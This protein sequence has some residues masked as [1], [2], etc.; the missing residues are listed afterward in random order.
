MTTVP[1][2]TYY[3][4]AA[5]QSRRSI[6]VLAVR[7]QDTRS[8]DKCAAMATT[9]CSLLVRKL[10]TGRLMFWVQQQRYMYSVRRALGRYKLERANSWRRRCGL[11]P[12]YP[13]LYRLQRFISR[14]LCASFCACCH[15]GR[16]DRADFQGGGR[17]LK[18]LQPNTFENRVLKSFLGFCAGAL[19]TVLLNLVL[20]R[21]YQT[22][23]FVLFLVVFACGTFL[24]LGAA[25]SD[26]VRCLILLT[27]PQLF[28]RE[29][30]LALTAYIYF[31]VLT[32]PAENFAANVEVL[33]RG[34]SCGQEK[35]ANETRRMLEV[36]TSPLK[37]VYDRVK[38]VIKLL[39][40][41]GSL[42]KKAFL[43]IKNLFTEIFAAIRRAIRWLYN[44]VNVCNRRMGEPYE[45]CRKPLMDAYADCL[46]MMPDLLEWICSPVKAVEQVCYVAKVITV[47]CAI[48]AMIIDFV[49]VQVIDRIERAMRSFLERAYTA[50]YVNVTVTH[51]Y[52][53]SLEYSRTP[54]EV[55]GHVLGELHARVALF[56]A[57]FKLLSNGVLVGFLYVAYG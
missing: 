24:M 34:L 41:F 3:H 54:A 12:V 57:L 40:D 33:S 5:A 23:S 7:I 37:A 14:V 51:Q 4:N 16:L 26:T 11:Q 29:G 20:V 31:L 38:K 53:Y 10:F 50:F 27:L 8:Q 55:R 44:L 43:S 1:C 35:V 22:T 15:G 17:L 19:L 13:P 32:G 46:E 45:K 21:I 52:N 25:F 48:P 36:A 28:S 9:I 30:R 6:F 2:S 18:S 56:A 47:L 49:K 42:M 39:L